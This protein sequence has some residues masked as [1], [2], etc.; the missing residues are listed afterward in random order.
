MF[1]NQRAV[2]SE[3][4]PVTYSVNDPFVA[5][6]LKELKSRDLQ[7]YEK[8]IANGNITFLQEKNE[9][10]VQLACT[11]N[12]NYSCFPT[13]GPN[14]TC[15]FVSSGCSGCSFTC[16]YQFKTNGSATV[17]QY[18]QNNGDPFSSISGIGSCGSASCGLSCS[19]IQAALP[20]GSTTTTTTYAPILIT[21]SGYNSSQA[22]PV[23]TVNNSAAEDAPMTDCRILLVSPNGS[24]A[25]LL[26]SGV[27]GTYGPVGSLK[28]SQG[29]SSTYTAGSGAG[30]Y[31]PTV[32]SGDQLVA[33]PSYYGAPSPPYL[34]S[35]SGL[36]S[37]DRNGTWTMYIV[38]GTTQGTPTTTTTTPSATTTTTPAPGGPGWY[39]ECDFLGGSC[40][41]FSS[42]PSINDPLLVTIGPFLTNSECLTACGNN[43]C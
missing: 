28:F 31:L 15:T 13:G 32:A 43:F 36:D 1:L 2:G 38:Q 21:T 34:T 35:F 24:K 16:P 23:V 3:K 14:Q 10:M 9:P 42:D 39:C 7:A 6:A 40:G 8:V 19:N 17:S 41:Y 20:A 5:G 30:Y 12:C 25:L 11:G 4:V 33:F 18:A 27:T 22:G 29:A 37:S 26:L